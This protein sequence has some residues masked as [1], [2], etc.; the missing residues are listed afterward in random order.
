MDQ[1]SPA[2]PSQPIVERF[3]AIIIG[4]GQAGNP[5]AHNLADA[6][7]RVALIEREHLGGSCVNYGCTPTKAMLASA[8]IAHEVRRGQSMGVH[9]GQVNVNLS[10]IVAR[11]NRLVKEWRSGQEHHAASRPNITLVRG[12]ARFLGPKRVSVEARILTAERIFINTGTS[13]LV[14]P[15]EGIRDVPYLTN[16]N[17]MDLTDIP[18]HLIVI[19]GSYI[20]LEFGQMFRRFGAQV[21]VMEYMERIIPLEDEDVSA[22]LQE[23][24]EDEGMVFRLA[25]RAA[26]V[27]ADDAG[28]IHVTVEERDGGAAQE[29]VG[30]HLLLAAGR[31]PNTDA[32][33]LEAAGVK[34]NRGWIVVNEFLETNVPGVYALGDVKGGPAFT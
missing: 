33:N 22:A 31:R 14:L 30:S 21:T 2:A 26:Q 18:E 29:I 11:K 10:E 3:D 19:G 17:V 34:T 28:R 27:R 7:W 32:L 4:S 9:A 5:L 8:Q 1:A 20:G 15:I 12:E 13:P 25:S 16:R 24:L 6:G 23:A